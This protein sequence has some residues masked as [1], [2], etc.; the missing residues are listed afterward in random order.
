METVV[1]QYNRD[2]AKWE[3]Q[4]KEKS[5]LTNCPKERAYAAGSGSCRSR[6]NNE[7]SQSRKRNPLTETADRHRKTAAMGFPIIGGIHKGLAPP[8]F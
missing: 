3:Q 2:L 5:R 8:A 4:V 1:E 7:I 6:A